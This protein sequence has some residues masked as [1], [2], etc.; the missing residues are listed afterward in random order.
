[1]PKLLGTWAAAQPRQGHPS[2]V[3]TLS[4]NRDGNTAPPPA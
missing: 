1:M 2:W 3:P 4:Q